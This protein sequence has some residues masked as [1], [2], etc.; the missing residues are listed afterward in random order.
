MNAELNSPRE[1]L[2]KMEAEERAARD[3][4]ERLIADNAKK[5][6]GTA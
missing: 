5:E 1:L 2:G 6:A 4:A 3:A